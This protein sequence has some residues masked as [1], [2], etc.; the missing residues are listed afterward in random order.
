MPSTSCGGT[1]QWCQGRSQQIAL[2]YVWR[3]DVNAS[4][5]NAWQIS[6]LYRMPVERGWVASSDTSG[7]CR[8]SLKKSNCRQR[9]L[10]RR[11]WA[12]ASGHTHTHWSVLFSVSLS[13]SEKLHGVWFKHRVSC[14]DVPAGALGRVLFQ[15]TDR[16]NRSILKAETRVDN[17]VRP[18]VF[19]DQLTRLWTRVSCLNC[20]PLAKWR[21]MS[22]NL[23][24]SPTCA[25]ALSTWSAKR[26][27]LE[28]V[29]RPSIA[30]RLPLRR[31][32]LSWLLASLPP[33]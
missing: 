8:V 28:H 14:V 7:W 9:C 4:V 24:S 11:T 25:F 18:C 22:R 31:I 30:I 3:D 2:S 10:S 33:F 26:A 13:R 29:R 5:Y 6:P 15:E 27:P 32:S 19:F 1:R 23:Q 12:T 21:K 16:R 20:E 17:E